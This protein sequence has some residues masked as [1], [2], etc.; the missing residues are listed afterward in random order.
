[1]G[2]GDSTETLWSAAIPWRRS[3]GDFM[4]CSDPMS[5]S[6]QEAAIQGQQRSGGLQPRRGLQR[7]CRLWATYRSHSQRPDEY[8]EQVRRRSD[9]FKAIPTYVYILLTHGSNTLRPCLR[10]ATTL[11]IPPCLSSVASLRIIEGFSDSKTSQ[12]L[13]EGL[14]LSVSLSKR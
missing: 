10:N 8:V 4:G 9:E 7:S 11:E 5:C 3:F 14:S 6:L 12:M 1:M 13:S 2:C